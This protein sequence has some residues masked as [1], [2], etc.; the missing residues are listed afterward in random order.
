MEVKLSIGQLIQTIDGPGNTL[1]SSELSKNQNTGGTLKMAW[2]TPSVTE[3]ALGAEI[4]A[5]ACA[6]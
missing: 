1:I 6:E 4:N 5:Y 2:N 3:I